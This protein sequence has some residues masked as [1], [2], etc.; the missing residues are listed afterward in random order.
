MENKIS[1]TNILTMNENNFIEFDSDFATLPNVSSLRGVQNPSIRR[2]K[3]T[4]KEIRDYVNLKYRLTGTNREI[5]FP[6]NIRRTK[7]DLISFIKQQKIRVRMRNL[8]ERTKH[9]RGARTVAQLEWTEEEIDHFANF[10]SRRITSNATTLYEMWN[11][12]QRKQEDIG[13][14]GFITLIFKD[15]RNQVIRRRMPT[16]YMTINAD[17]TSSFE[18]F[19]QRLE[20]I[21][22]GGVEGSDKFRPNQ[23]KLVANVFD[24][25]YVSSQ[26]AFGQSNKMF[27]KTYNIKGDEK[28]NIYC[29]NKCLS[30]AGYVFKNKIYKLDDLMK[31]LNIENE[32]KMPFF[33]I[34]EY[35]KMLDFDDEY[36]KKHIFNIG[37][38]F[39]KKFE[40]WEVVSNQLNQKKN[41]YIGSLQHLKYVNKLTKLKGNTTI[42]KLISN[43]KDIAIIPNQLYLARRINRVIGNRKHNDIYSDKKRGD[44][45]IWKLKNEDLRKKFEEYGLIFGD[46]KSCKYTFIYD[47]IDKHLDV[48]K[49]NKVVLDDVYVSK[50]QMF[51]KR[52]RIKKKNKFIKIMSRTQLYRRNDDDN[53]KSVKLKYV[54]FDF[55]TIIDWLKSS[56]MNPY[57]LSWFVADDNDLRNLD[58]YDKNK[59]LNKINQLIKTNLFNS[60]GFN[61]IDVFYKWIV[62]NQKDTIFK[63]ISFNGANFDNFILFDWLSR[64]KANNVSKPFY[65]GTQLLD[66]TINGRHSTFDIRKHLVGTLKKCCVD[67]KI[68][69]CAKKDLDHTIAQNYYDEFGKNMLDANDECKKWTK[70]MIDYNNYDVLSLG[71]LFWRY[72]KALINT[73]CLT[74]Y[75]E[76]LHKYLTI[77]SIIYK[78]F[79]NQ[80]KKEKIKFDKLDLK[81]YQ[82][83]QKSK[84]AGRVEMF[85]GVQ[86]VLEE[87]SSIDVCSLYPFVCSILDVY[88]PHGKIINFENFDEF[89]KIQQEK[90]NPIY[91]AYC[92]FDQSN[93]K[94]KNLPLIVCEKT[95]I[96]NDWKTK[97]V[98]KNVLLSFV[99]IELLL[100]YECEITIHNG[101]YF[102]EKV[103]NFKMFGFLLDL[104]KG[105][106]EQDEYKRNK[107]ER[108]NNALREVKK[109]TS[110]AISGKVIEGL[111]CD[112]V[113]DVNLYKYMKIKNDP[114]TE[115]IN[116]INI[117]GDKV[118]CSYKKNEDSCIN[119]QRPI[120]LG[121]LIYDYAKRY[122]FENS[123]SIVGLKNLL[124]TDTDACKFRKKHFKKWFEEYANKKIVPHWKEIEKVDPRYETHKLYSHSTKVYGSFEE[125]LESGNTGII[126]TNKK[127]W[128]VQNGGKDKKTKEIIDKFGFK[129][130]GR[131]D[132]TITL[133]E[134]FVMKEWKKKGKII[135]QMCG[136]KIIIDGIIDSDCKF[137]Y[138]ITTQQLAYDFY[139]KN[140][141]LAFEKNC[142]NIFNNLFDNGFVYILQ[143][144]FRKIIKNT[145]RNVDIEDSE[146]FENNC[147]KIK[148]VYSI[149]KIKISNTSG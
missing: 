64:N 132:K 17:H 81:T 44:M 73:K 133:N 34:K 108:Y 68:K 93:L 139:N 49:N 147:N 97:N 10:S 13:E 141:H 111:H 114:N 23:Y 50:S 37:S 45:K 9:R 27:Y 12:I 76:E 40:K 142:W 127:C 25:N 41:I 112:K 116:C 89:K 1:T 53:K 59:N 29:I 5:T 33:S 126:I 137:N 99:N 3:K 82:D 43:K 131:N 135:K 105:K 91:F 113:V 31:W 47:S 95:K 101:F 32:N 61:N 107:D 85:N 14:N 115:Q 63:F 78:C 83:M 36:I 52:I 138:K 145:R 62:K 46:L 129:G 103:K 90:K 102:E 94:T 54:F 57:S 146:K 11:L 58:M 66:F 87:I 96:G 30:H 7:E 104:M 21:Q 122:M 20:N 98:L 15:E 84:I 86:R 65:N 92:D 134:N 56:C 100:K 24:I 69:C 70:E 121:V 149:K 6:L 124:Y 55:E 16:R 77:G 117:I 136:E 128:C 39:A 120:F 109:L 140:K 74:K 8:R 18:E 143:Q 28:N 123:Y 48:I 19:R 60:S 80:C 110:N 125:E 51:F 2:L 79:Q 71:L 67:F 118:F 35:L 38:E 119:S 4:A 88:F 42:F 106:N 72:K 75:G 144:S 22:R 26:E 148:V 130:V